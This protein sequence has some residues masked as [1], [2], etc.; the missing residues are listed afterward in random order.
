MHTFL[1][2]AKTRY[3]VRTFKSQP[4][5]PEKLAQ[6]LEVG[7]VAPTACNNQ[8]Q[9]IKVI[10]DPADLAKAD[11]CT[12]CR[13]NAPAL[14]LVCYDRTACWERKFDGADSG[15]VDAS[16]VT[17]HLRGDQICTGLPH[18]EPWGAE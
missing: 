6:I 8:P 13:F 7:R 16:I 15:E 2:L 9:R 4:I 10:T 11:E 5:E 14:L 3:S 18:W 1:E 17:T 12:P